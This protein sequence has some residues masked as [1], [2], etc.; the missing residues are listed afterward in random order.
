M[1]DGREMRKEWKEQHLCALKERGGDGERESM[2]YLD[3]TFYFQ[4]D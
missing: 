2:P 3:I 4:L 1:G